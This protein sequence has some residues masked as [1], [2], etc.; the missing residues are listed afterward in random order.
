M[1]MLVMLLCFAQDQVNEAAHAFMAVEFIDRH[2][3]MRG[4]L[5]LVMTDDT[6]GAIDIG[7]RM[8]YP[9]GGLFV[10][11]GAFFGQN[12]FCDA[13]DERCDAETVI[14]AY[15]EVGVHLWLMN[16]MRVSLFAR[17][18]TTMSNIE[19]DY[20]MYGIAIGFR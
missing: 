19:N 15:P 12:R 6:Y 3:A 9:T 10:G 16:T 14:G 1:S 5:S 18:Y 7:F 8:Q 11:V 17:Y 20:S 2:W 4:D 13:R